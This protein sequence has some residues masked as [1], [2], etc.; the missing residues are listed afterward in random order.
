MTGIGKR[1]YL[2]TSSVKGMDAGPIVTI[3]KQ[4]V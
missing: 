3:N 1:K 4:S 2:A